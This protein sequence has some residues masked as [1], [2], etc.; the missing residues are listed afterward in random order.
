MA[1]TTSYCSS[2]GQARSLAKCPDTW[3]TRCVLVCKCL[4]STLPDTLWGRRMS[5]SIPVVVLWSWKQ[6]EQKKR[7]LYAEALRSAMYINRALTFNFFL[8]KSTNYIDC[9]L[10]CSS[11]KYYIL[12]SV[13]C[14][15]FIFSCWDLSCLL[16][17][18]YLLLI[19]LYC[20]YTLYIWFIFLYIY[21]KGFNAE[22]EG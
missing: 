19:L 4:W 3:T 15:S 21:T 9:I 16:S 5:S 17:C 2:L 22:R 20:I 6:A 8:C 7:Q 12:I 10:L 13:V 11:V 1:I 14:L 18:Y